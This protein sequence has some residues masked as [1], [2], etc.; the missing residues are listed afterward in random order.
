M[1]SKLGWSQGQSLGKNDSGIL[2]PIPLT[3]N[4]GTTGLGSESVTVTCNNRD[5]KKSLMWRKTQERYKN[6]PPS[7][8]FNQS[9]SE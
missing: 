6:L 5:M 4:T 7:D 2:E 3:S 8:I 9:D 1:L